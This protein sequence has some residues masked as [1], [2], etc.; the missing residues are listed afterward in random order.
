MTR[1]QCTQALSNNFWWTRERLLQKTT[2]FGSTS[3][4]NMTLISSAWLTKN[5]ST[6][7]QKNLTT[8]SWCLNE[9][10]SASAKNFAPN[11]ELILKSN[12]RKC[13]RKTFLNNST[14]AKERSLNWTQRV[15]CNICTNLTFR[16]GFRNKFCAR[17]CT[18]RTVTT[19]TS[20]TF[21]LT[22]SALKRGK[23]T[24][25]L[26][27]CPTCL[28]ATTKRCSKEVLTQ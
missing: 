26:C 5:K 1:I 17:S 20:S 8:C 15:A 25:S 14:K 4:R 12:C 3:R 21:S 7:I 6:K 16:F 18:V 22:F 11:A 10:Y 2:K 13:K 23:N 24:S 27:L 19:W 28:L 9:K